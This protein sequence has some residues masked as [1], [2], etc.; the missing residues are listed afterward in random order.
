MKEEKITANIIKRLWRRSNVL[1]REEAM[2]EPC[3]L[4]RLELGIAAHFFE[5]WQETLIWSAL[6]GVMGAVFVED[7][8]APCTAMIIIAD[9][10]FLAG[11]PDEDFIRQRPEGF[12]AQFAILVPKDFFWQQ[13]IEQTLPG[14]VK[15]VTRYAIRKN[16]EFDI[17]KLQEIVDS[18]EDVYQLKMIDMAA[19][20]EISR[21]RWAC[22]LCS[23]FETYEKYRELGIGTV[24]YKGREL[25]AGASSY[26]IYEGGIEIEIDT[27]E[28]YQRRGLAL[29]CGAKLI[30]ACLEKGW[31]PSWD[32][33]NIGSVRLAEKLGYQFAEEYTAYECF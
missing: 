13:M 27:K 16:T 7:K 33:Q 6:Q 31:Y 29:V 14:R 28:S 4:N 15:K 2:A 11:K 9:F 26:T 8:K 5:D 22:D 1:Q 20:E 3:L 24:I 32:A 30:L 10:V 23:Q 25:V 19:Y 21:T 12:E 17:K 18:L